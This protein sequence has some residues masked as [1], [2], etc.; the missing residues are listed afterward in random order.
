M[1]AAGA[2]LPPLRPPIE[3]LRRREHPQRLPQPL[4]GRPGMFEVDATW[5]RIQPLQL[6]PGVATV[7]ELEVIQAIEAGALIVDCRLEE[8]LKGGSIP[9][10]VAIPHGEIV[11]GLAPVRDAEEPVVLF[12]NGPQCGATP[13]AIPALLGA[14]W[15]PSRLRYYRGGLHDWITLGLPLAPPRWGLGDGAAARADR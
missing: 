5:G 7:G 4:D 3:R 1:S 9:T 8:Y 2:A 11:A 14:G 6:V 12:C 15:E 10:A 13:D